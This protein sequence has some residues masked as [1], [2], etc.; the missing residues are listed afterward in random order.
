M[1]V[2]DEI[3]ATGWLALWTLAW[4]ATVALAMFG[5]V[6]LWDRSQEVLSWAAVGLNLAGGVGW[7]V[8][9]T[10]YLRAIDELQRKIMQDA[11]AI[12]LGVGWIVAFAYVVADSAGLV[13]QDFGVAA[14]SVLMAVVFMA[15]IFV[16]RIRYR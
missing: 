11:L 15:A 3:K 6:S 8:A 5:P 10:G 14:L 16:G 4:T 9:F 12:T 7:I 2:Q 13:S 1:Q